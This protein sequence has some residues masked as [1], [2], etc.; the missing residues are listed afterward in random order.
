MNSSEVK[1]LLESSLP[2]CDVLADGEGCNFQIAVVSS[3]FEGL[4]TVKRQ[5]LV[6]SHLQ[7]AIASGAIHAITM[8]TYT[9]EQKN[10]L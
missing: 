5:Q 4:N 3:A 10:A 1:T 6:Y 9:P 8:K 2:D 7:E